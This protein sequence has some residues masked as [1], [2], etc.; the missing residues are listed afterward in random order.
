[1]YK[2]VWTLPW[3]SSS[4]VK[5]KKEIIFHFEHLVKIKNCHILDIC[6]KYKNAGGLSM[7]QPGNDQVWGHL[8]VQQSFQEF[9]PQ[10]ENSDPNARVLVSCLTCSILTS[11]GSWGLPRSVWLVSTSEV[12]SR[13]QSGRALSSLLIW[14]CL[15]SFLLESLLTR[16]SARK[17]SQ[18]REV[19]RLPPARAS[20][21]SLKVMSCRGGENISNSTAQSGQRSGQTVRNKLNPNRRRMSTTSSQ[22]VQNGSLYGA[23]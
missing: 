4:E 14:W 17:I 13:G 8:N 6:W 9:P 15:F 18:N 7:F 21:S 11:W 12:V 22:F 1:M 23:P 19:R 20:R 10:T 16:T 5:M 2:Y 3:W